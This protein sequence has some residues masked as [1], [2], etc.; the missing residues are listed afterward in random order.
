MLTI[1]QAEHGAILSV[2]VRA[3][4]RRNGVSGMREG[5]LLID[6]TAA[7]EKGRANQTVLTIMADALGLPKSSLEIVSGATSTRKRV[8]VRGISV[9]PLRASL[10]SYFPA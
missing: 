8:L 10:A 6:V 7:P 9:E 3:R 5:M 2:K 4:A 1:E